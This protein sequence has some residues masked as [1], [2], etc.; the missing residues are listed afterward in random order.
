MKK[1]E[2]RRMEKSA[3]FLELLKKN[4]PDFYKDYVKKYKKTVEKKQARRLGGQGDMFE[5]PV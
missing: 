4:A 3:E 1:K 5:L 2:Q